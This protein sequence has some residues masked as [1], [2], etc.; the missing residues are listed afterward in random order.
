[1]NCQTHCYHYIYGG[2]PIT[3][4]CDAPLPLVIT[5]KLQ[6]YMSVLTEDELTNDEVEIECECFEEKG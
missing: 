6:G 4:R 2:D 1:M 3:D 5:D